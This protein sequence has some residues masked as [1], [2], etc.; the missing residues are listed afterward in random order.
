[1]RTCSLGRI[2]R[3]C[4]SYS[5]G[6][7]LQLPLPILHS[8]RERRRW[9]PPCAG[10]HGLTFRPPARFGSMA[11][12]E[13]R[14]DGASEQDETSRHRMMFKAAP[15]RSSAVR[16]L[17]NAPPDFSRPGLTIIKR[18][19]PHRP[20]LQRPPYSDEPVPD[21]QGLRGGRGRY[22]SR[23]R[24]QMLSLSLAGVLRAEVNLATFML[25]QICGSYQPGP[26]AHRI[27]T[28]Q[29]TTPAVI[30]TGEH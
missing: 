12:S 2:H 22:R 21:L 15:C 11:E 1:M 14:L 5:R 30:G 10:P 26:D 13:L 25:Y 7:D 9:G 19:M 4:I 6:L 8:S 17:R 16:N 28:H 20:K 18:R 3:T 27:V 29:F 24:R 23:G